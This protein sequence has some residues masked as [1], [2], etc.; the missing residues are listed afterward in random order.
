MV[1][2]EPLTYSVREA[3]QL[4]GLSRNSVYQAC[5]KGEIPSVRIGRRI[6]IPKAKLRQ[7]LGEDE[8]KDGQ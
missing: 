6:L 7:Q 3:A 4:L 5:L 8:D 2:N 1:T